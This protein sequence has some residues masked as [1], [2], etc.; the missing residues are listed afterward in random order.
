MSVPGNWLIVKQW[1][2][3]TKQKHKFNSTSIPSQRVQTTNSVTE[4][5]NIAASKGSNKIVQLKQW[6]LRTKE[7]LKKLT[8]KKGQIHWF[9]VSFHLQSSCKTRIAF[10][11]AVLLCVAE[12]F[13][14]IYSFVR[15]QPVSFLHTIHQNY[16]DKRHTVLALR[17]TTAKVLYGRHFSVV[18]SFC[19]LKNNKY[20]CAYSV[21]G[22]NCGVSAVN[23]G[24]CCVVVV[25]GILK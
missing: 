23:C 14:F 19:A 9:Q 4:S 22:S 18:V 2:N 25:F 7:I 20:I 6:R 11:S 1:R 17:H 24:G 3:E 8:E 21:Y 15:W 16:T 13:V 5:K 12:Q 10:G